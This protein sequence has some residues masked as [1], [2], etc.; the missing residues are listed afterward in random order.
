MVNEL[1]EGLHTI[2]E[3]VQMLEADGGFEVVLPEVLARRVAANTGMKQQCPLPT[4]PWADEAGNL[5]KCWLPGDGK[6]C[7]MTCEQPS[8]L[9]IPA[10]CDLNVCSNLKLAPSKLHFICADTGKVC[11]SR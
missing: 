6:S 7:V 3:T 11:P 9:H 5:P 2:I 1:G 8:A 4:G 10:A